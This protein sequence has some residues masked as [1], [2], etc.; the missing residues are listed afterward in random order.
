MAELQ[1]VWSWQP[2]LYLFLGGMGAGAFVMAGM[3]YYKFRAGNERVICVSA[4]AATICLCVGL[5]LLVTELTNPLRGMMLWQSFTHFTSWMTIGAWILLCAVIVFGLTAVLSTKTLVGIVLKGGRAERLAKLEAPVFKGLFPLGMVLGVGVAAYTGVLL[6]SAPGVPLWN[7][8]LLPCLFCVSGL[9]TGVALV[10]IVSISLEHWP[11]RAG[12]ST[13]NAPIASEGP[14]KTEASSVG[15]VSA[16]SEMSGISARVAA[17]E[18]STSVAASHRFMSRCVVVLIAVELLVLAGFLATSLSAGV[19]SFTAETAALSADLLLRGSLAPLFWVLVVVLGLVVPVAI[20][21]VG[22]RGR[23]VAPSAMAVGAVG[24]MAGGCALRFLVL[25][26]GLH[27][28]V[29]GN[30]LAAVLL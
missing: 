14:S 9:D 2:A 27:T 4:W 29:V 1:M 26:A 11:R 23:H 30:A 22:A 3:L 25:A 28:D 18:P 12:A 5:L 19:S 6:M 8:L 17:G 10:E 20:A 21:A 7:T 13:E 24:A 16:A 15:G